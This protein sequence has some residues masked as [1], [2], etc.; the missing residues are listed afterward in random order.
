MSDRT[1]ESATYPGA[2]AYTRP[3]IGVVL[4]HGITGT[5]TEMRPLARHLK[6]LG[7]RVEVPL[8][9]GHDA[10]YRELLATTWRDW[11]QGMRQAVKQM[12]T[13]CSGVVVVGLSA[14]GLLAALLADECPE[15][16]GLGLLALHFG[17]RGPN[18]SDASRVFYKMMALFPILRKKCYFVESPPYGLKDKRL[19][20]HITAAIA[21]SQQGQTSQFGLFR[22]YVDTLY[23]MEELEAQVRKVAPGIQCPAFMLHSVEDTMLSARNTAVMYGLIGSRDKYMRFISGCDHVI[24][25]DLQKEAVANDVGAFVM[26]LGAPS[27]M[28][29]AY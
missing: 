4:I 14:G 6:Q 22:T 10:G 9:P 19:Q 26:R 2:T 20:Q 1:L 3:D 5:P 16:V 12:A 7:Y 24:T 8:V 15:V 28:P 29:E 17:I 13:E 21:A 18:I 23:Q 11:L 25:V 27:F